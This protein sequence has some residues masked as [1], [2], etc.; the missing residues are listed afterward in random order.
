MIVLRSATLP[1]KKVMVKELE[2]HPTLRKSKQSREE[3]L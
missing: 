1:S 2:I 3:D